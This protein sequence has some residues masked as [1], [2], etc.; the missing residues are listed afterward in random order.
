M[1]ASTLILFIVFV[2]VE[3]GRCALSNSTLFTIFFFNEKENPAIQRLALELI[4]KNSL[5]GNLCN[6]T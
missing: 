4:A 1:E 3:S 6:W 2:F 5:I